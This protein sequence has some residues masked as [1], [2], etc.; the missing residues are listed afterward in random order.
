MLVRRF[1]STL[2]KKSPDSPWAS[3]HLRSL[4]LTTLTKT[5]QLWDEQIPWQ[6]LGEGLHLYL[7]HILQDSRAQPLI[8]LRWE[9][10]ACGRPLSSSQM[11][12]YLLIALFYC[13]TVVAITEILKTIAS[14]S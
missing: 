11:D 13:A 9:S 2:F 7:L 6:A 4:S 8:R 3:Q 14:I 1:P 5:H 12:L 10:R